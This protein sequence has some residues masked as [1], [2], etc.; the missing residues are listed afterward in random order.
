MDNEKKFKVSFSGF[1]YVTASSARE[2]MEKFEDDDCAY[3]EQQ[4]DSVEEVDEFIV[5]F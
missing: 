5:Y 1:A 3:T 4:Y 2:A